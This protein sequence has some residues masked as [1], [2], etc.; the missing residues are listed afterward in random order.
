VRAAASGEE[1]GDEAELFAELRRLRRT[2]ADARGIP[3]YMVF[4]DATLLEFAARR[5]STP[6]EFLSISGVGP[7]KLA[8]YGEPFL[9]VL[10]RQAPGL[11]P[12]ENPS[13]L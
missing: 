12:S 6:D 9:A 8:L 10:G 5:P 1:A 3:A 7:K 13:Q 11:A 4:S 2:L